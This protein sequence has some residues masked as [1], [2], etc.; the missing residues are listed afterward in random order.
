LPDF[1]K[2]HPPGLLLAF[3][4]SLC[5][6]SAYRSSKLV[7]ALFAAE[8]GAGAFDVGLIV[9]LY[10]LVPF[11]LAIFAGR[12]SDRFG[13]L[14]PMVFG[15]S[16][17][18]VGLLIPWV[19][20]GMPA[21]YASA[22]VLGGSYVFYHVSIQSLI[23]AFSTP[24]TRT[25][26]FATY[27]LVLAT[28]SFIGPLLSGFAIDAVGHARTYLLIAFVPV[29]SV[30]LML[31][32]RSRLP[33]LGH[34]E[35]RHGG[36]VRDLLANRALVRVLLTS[37]VILTG[38]DLFA[39]YLPIYGHAID[40]SASVIGTITAMFAAASFFVR[41]IMPS[42]VKRYGEE[43]VLTRSLLL[44][45]ATYMLFPFFTDPWVLGAIAF[46]L[47]MGLGCGQPLSMMLTY[48]RAPTGRSGEA[49]GLRLTVNHFTHVVTPL[50]FGAIGTVFGLGPVFWT[51]ALFLAG[52]GVLIR[53]R[54]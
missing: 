44:S 16:G 10:A 47:G 5:N 54:R 18:A 39:F 48:A 24:Q 21:L 50:A 9:S 1:L 2:R 20:P 30:A 38:I 17:V 14:R 12:L 31:A 32:G 8:L 15:T 25:Q 13:I 27:S 46:V 4:F 42:L 52:G 43:G 37:G 53:R 28:G 51:N 41:S 49:L 45:G 40:L 22:A 33:K 6:V 29:L 11:G 7:M 3:A 26:N 34:G 36:P 19:W 23:G 35:S